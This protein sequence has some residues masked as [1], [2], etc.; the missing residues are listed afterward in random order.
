MK[1]LLILLAVASVLAN[2]KITKQSKKDCFPLFKSVYN[3]CRTMKHPEKKCKQIVLVRYNECVAETY[4][5][6]MKALKNKGKKTT[7]VE[8]FTEKIVAEAMA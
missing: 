7:D 1:L 6:E 8:K 3:N 5:K 2:E 4:A